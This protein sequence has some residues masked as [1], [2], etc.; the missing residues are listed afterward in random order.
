MTGGENEIMTL[1]MGL[2]LGTTALKIALFDNTGKLLAVSTQE[3]S[4]ITPAVNFVEEDVEVYWTAFKDGLNDLKSQYPIKEEDQISMAISAQGETLICI[5]SEGNPLRNAIVWMDNRAGE[6]AEELRARFGDETC[7]KVTGQVSFEPCWPASKILWLKKHEEDIFNRTY[8][9]LLIE[10]Y[11][12]YRMT[13]CFAAEGSL[14]CSTTYWNITTKKYWP[15]MLEC[16][17]IREDQLPPVLESGEI[18]GTMNPEIMEELGLNAQSVIVCTGALDQAAG[19]IGV[20]NVHEGMFSENIGSALAICVPVSRPVFDPNRKMPLHY[21]AIPDMYMMHTF[22]TGGM[23]LRW[24]RDKFCGDEMAIEQL[25]DVSAY[26]LLDKEAESVPAGAEGL[27]MLPHLSGSLA[28]DVNAKAKGVWFGFTLKHTKAHFV[29]AVFEAVGYTLKRNIDALADMGI[30]VDEVRSLGGGS[31][32]AVWSQIK[33][34]ITGKRMLTTKSK[35]AACLGVALL[36]GKA[37]G[38]FKDIDSA[39]DGMVE[40]KSVFEPDKENEKAYAEG[41]DMYRNLFADLADCFEKTK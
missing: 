35:E 40:I 22:T 1:L 18:V 20:G 6:E 38:V 15:E 33:S 17:G 30:H 26:A 11:F 21:F 7:Y 2:D 27:V 14:V 41:Y 19:A 5:D 24:F 3:Y 10:D 32:S 39:A 23:A 29:R 9:F 16:L 28:P 37:T 8:K 25:S 13:G 4:L 36:A 12:I 34:D 31:R